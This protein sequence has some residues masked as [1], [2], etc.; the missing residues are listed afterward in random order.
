MLPNP[1]EPTFKEESI[2][3]ERRFFPPDASA[4][5]CAPV[6][7]GLTL[8]QKL[9]ACIRGVRWPILALRKTQGGRGYAKQQ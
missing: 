3:S 1:F 8:L 7:C 6:K 4:T 5:A 9:L 2:L